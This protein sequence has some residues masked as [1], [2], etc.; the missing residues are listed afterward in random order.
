ME[1]GGY[2]RLWPARDPPFPSTSDTGFGF[3]CRHLPRGAH[4]RPAAARCHE[5]DEERGSE[6]LPWAVG[7]RS[8]FIKFPTH[9]QDHGDA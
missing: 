6:P 2:S 4:K 5:A 8:N 1:V 9:T 3:H 7:E